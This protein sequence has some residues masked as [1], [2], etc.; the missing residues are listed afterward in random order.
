LKRFFSIFLL[1]ILFVPTLFKLSVEIYYQLNKEYIAA[2]LCMN[3]ERPI[4]MC[5]GRCFVDQ[6]IQL[7]DETPVTSSSLSQ[8]APDLSDFLISDL[9][10]QN[11]ST[12][13]FREFSL[14]QEPPLVDGYLL[15][16]FRPPLA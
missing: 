5:Y 6:K 7:I 13:Q 12:N 2:N 1:L 3:K 10:F 4:T 14:Q 11:R 16:V 15:C 8:V 9:D